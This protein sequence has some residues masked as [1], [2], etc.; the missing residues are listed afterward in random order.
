MNLSELGAAPFAL[1]GAVFLLVFS[2]LCRGGFRP[3]SCVSLGCNAAVPHA[4]GAVLFS[5]QWPAFRPVFL[6]YVG[7]AF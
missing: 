6:S 3:P 5:L 2:F 4:R 7:T 1:K